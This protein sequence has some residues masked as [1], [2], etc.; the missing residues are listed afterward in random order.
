VDT[1]DELLLQERAA[2]DD[3]MLA[4]N[5]AIERMAPQQITCWDAP[6]VNSRATSGTTVSGDA[7]TPRLIALI[8]PCGRFEALADLRVN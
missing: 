8:K 5:G 3:G 6:A 1:E 4:A 2:T 7:N